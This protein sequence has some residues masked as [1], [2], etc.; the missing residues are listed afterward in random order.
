MASETLFVVG[1]VFCVPVS[2]VGRRET[3]RHTLD[4]ARRIYAKTD[5]RPPPE[6]MHFSSGLRRQAASI[7]KSMIDASYCD[8]SL[9]GR[10]QNLL[11]HSRLCFRTS[12]V[13]P[14]VIHGL[15]RRTMNPSLDIRVWTL[16]DSCH[17]L[18]V[19]QMRF[20]RMSCLMLPFGLEQL[21]SF[22]I[23]FGSH[24]QKCPLP[25]KWLIADICPDSS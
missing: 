12:M 21:T 3:L 24:F 17:F 20:R 15:G 7:V 13:S 1:A 4:S 14:R 11:G 5:G 23:S 9:S 18:P 25:G 22:S 6:E 19:E 2:G 8:Q 10:A 16:A